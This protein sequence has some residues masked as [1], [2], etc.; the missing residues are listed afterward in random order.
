M[1]SSSKLLK[2][3]FSKLYFNSYFFYMKCFEL[4]LKLTYYS[5]V[6]SKP[7]LYPLVITCGEGDGKSGGSY[8]MVHYFRNY[9]IR[10]PGA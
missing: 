9:V 2:I 6:T 1:S 10:A 5:Q 4:F 8:L 7:D 3:I